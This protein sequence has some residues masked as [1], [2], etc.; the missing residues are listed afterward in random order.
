MR[1]GKPSQTARAAA[2]HRAAHQVLEEGR[3]FADPLAFR[4]LGEDVKSIVREAEEHPTGR[5]MRIFIAAR[6]RFAE[7]ALMAAFER[8]PV[9]SSCWGPVWTPARI[10][11][12]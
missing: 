12:D 5:R 7:D 2:V 3:I 11:A 1:S 6:T 4:I 9:N 10:A 8:G